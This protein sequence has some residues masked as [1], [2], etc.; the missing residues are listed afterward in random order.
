MTSTINV[1]AKQFEI[2][3]AESF[4]QLV[5]RQQILDVYV[6]LFQKAIH[7]KITGETFETILEELMERHVKLLPLAVNEG[8][9]IASEMTVIGAFER[10]FVLREI[11]EIIKQVQ[12]V[13]EML[14]I[15]THSLKQYSEGR[16]LNIFTKYSLDTTE[17]EARF[18]QLFFYTKYL[19]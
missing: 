15:H 9:M 5:E 19:N 3:V 10:L 8:D 1:E 2:E 11:E 17:L 16:L 13:N 6:K 12:C 14:L 18:P 7:K 4:K